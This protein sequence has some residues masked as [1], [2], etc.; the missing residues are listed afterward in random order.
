MPKRK[1][2]KANWQRIL[3][4]KNEFIEIYQLD[5]HNAFPSN[6][7]VLILW[8]YDVAAA[9]TLHGESSHLNLTSTN[10]TDIIGY[11]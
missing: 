6:I 11:Q 1:K 9:E 2:P 4:K 7:H 5:W 3:H 8:Q 10:V